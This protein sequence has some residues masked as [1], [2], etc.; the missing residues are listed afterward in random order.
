MSFQV[1]KNPATA[2][3]LE[4]MESVDVEAGRVHRRVLRGAYITHNCTRPIN[5]VAFAPFE[6]VLGVGTAGGFQSLLCPGA[7]EPN[8]DALEENPFANPRY[9]QEREIRR[10]LNKVCIINFV[11]L[12]FLFLPL[13]I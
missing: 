12:C 5:Q 13:P 1:L 2:A 3:D 10:L 9:R 7:G 11:Y 8:F 4:N 6:D